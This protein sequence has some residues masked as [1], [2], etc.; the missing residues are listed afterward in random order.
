MFD[1][2]E[3]NERDNID[4]IIKIINDIINNEPNATFTLMGYSMGGTIALMVGIYFSKKQCISQIV[5]LSSQT[6]G[7]DKLNLI[8]CPVIF[9][10]SINDPVIPLKYIYK[11]IESYKGDTKTYLLTCDH[12]WSKVN[13]IWVINRLNL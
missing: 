13:M 2:I 7:F 10:H 3:C 9:F 11:W 4:N 8:S 6:V 12:A 1:T 5:F